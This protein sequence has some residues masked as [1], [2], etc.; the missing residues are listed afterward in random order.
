[1]KPGKALPP[2]TEADAKITPSDISLAQDAWRRDAPP[3]FRRMLDAK[4]KKGTER[5]G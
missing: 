5:D 2:A 3:A 4:V 1:M